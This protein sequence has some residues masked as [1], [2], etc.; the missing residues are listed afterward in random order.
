MAKQY[1]LFE[2]LGNGRKLV[3]KTF[4]TF[5]QAWQE[6]KQ[7]QPVSMELDEDHAECADAYTKDG[8]ILAIQ[9]VG[10]KIDN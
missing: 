5:D 9:P 4:P 10:F 8:R 3:F 1:E 7:M 2:S 6:L